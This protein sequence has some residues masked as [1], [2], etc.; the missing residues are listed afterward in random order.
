MNKLMMTAIVAATVSSAFAADTSYK[1][2]DG[3]DITDPANWNGNPPQYDATTNPDTALYFSKKSPAPGETYG[4]TMNQD[5]T[6]YTVKLHKQADG[7]TKTGLN[8]DVD[9]GG[10]TLTLMSGLTFNSLN[11]NNWA[12]NYDGAHVRFHDGT[13]NSAGISFAN[14]SNDKVGRNSSIVLDNVIGSGVFYVAA[15]NVQVVI[16]N[17]TK[18]TGTYATT[19][20]AYSDSVRALVTGPGTAVNLNGGTL[21]TNGR[22]STQANNCLSNS[23]VIADHA[24][25]TNGY[26]VWVTGVGGVLK[27]LDGSYLQCSD[28]LRYEGWGK[29]TLFQ[30]TNGSRCDCAYADF[31]RYGRDTVV[32]ISGKGTVF[33]VNKAPANGMAFTFCNQSNSSNNK[34]WLHDGAVV[35]N[36]NV[37]TA[38]FGYDTA[39]NNEIILEGG[40][41]FWM[42]SDINIATYKGRRTSLRVDTG[43]WIEGNRMRI[44]Q[45]GVAQTNTVFIGSNA[46]YVARDWIE[47]RG[48][49][50]NKLTVSNGTM[51][52]VSNYFSIGAGWDVTI[53]GREPRLEGSGGVSFGASCTLTFDIPAEGY[54]PDTAVLYKRDSS[55]W[56]D[57][58]SVPVPAFKMDKFRKVGGT[59]ILAEGA[60]GVQLSDEK[61]AAWQA[62]ANAAADGYAKCKIS[63]VGSSKSTEGKRLVLTVKPKKGLAVIVK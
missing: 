43:A 13:F 55:G 16:T 60:L 17:G 48:G 20:G 51:R 28:H 27:V 11:V 3:G 61:Q 32:D 58:N 1:G 35:T 49:E 33:S 9:L 4:V 18:W 36:T 25:V 57:M 5:L 15:T 46:R 24:V 31:A 62:A 30:M 54:D 10:H 2:A 39:H 47:L 38:E 22:F 41:S 56:W 14:N 45:T 34:F 29:G 44:G 7:E 52:A 40:A 26:R 50:A 63:I 59:V 12:K 37:G 19:D 8:L 53:A 23:F 21:Q 42:P 6:A